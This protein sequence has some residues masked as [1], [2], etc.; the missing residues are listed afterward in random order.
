MYVYRD[1]APCKSLISQDDLRTFHATHFPHAPAHRH[2]LHGVEQDPAEELDEEEDDGLGYYSDGMKRTLTDEQIAIFRNSE[3]QRILR[4]RRLRKESGDISEEGETKS[5]PP[6]VTVKLPPA[7]TVSG[8]SNSATQPQIQQWA[9][10]SARTKARNKK[11]RDRYKLKKKSMREQRE[12]A[13]KSSRPARDE[14][15]ESD[16][17][18]P[19]H[20]ANGPDAQ[21]E[22]ALELDY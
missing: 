14:D 11:H 3:I 15:E 19:W 5:S 10:S 9:T 7:P 12:Q 4:A 16:E 13:K 2:I 20:Q 21:K 18:D 6:Q 1:H 22:D 17:W 8:V